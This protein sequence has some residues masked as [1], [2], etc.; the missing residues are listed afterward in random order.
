MLT[1]EQEEFLQLL[2]AE[3]FDSE[4]EHWCC[5]MES[6]YGAIDYPEF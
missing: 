6:E 4:F 3:L 1:R 2:H 5:E